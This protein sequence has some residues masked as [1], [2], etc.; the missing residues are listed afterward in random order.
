[1]RENGQYEFIEFQIRGREYDPKMFGIESV[2]PPTRDAPYWE[3]RF[4]DESTIL[5]NDVITIRFRIN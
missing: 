4:K 5:T 2:T 3:I 1:M